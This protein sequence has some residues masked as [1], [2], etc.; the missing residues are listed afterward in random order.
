MVRVETGDCKKIDTTLNIRIYRDFLIKIYA[1]TRSDEEENEKI[2]PVST[3]KNRI[4]FEI[5]TAMTE[6]FF[7]RQKSMY[8]WFEAGDMCDVICVIFRE[9]MVIMTLRQAYIES[10]RRGWYDDSPEQISGIERR[11][12]CQ[13]KQLKITG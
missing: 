7:L 13:K 11:I 12:Q 3:G 8:R 9:G 4:I 1:T 5:Q 2:P 6:C 10:H